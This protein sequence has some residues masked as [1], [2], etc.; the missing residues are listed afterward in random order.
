MYLSTTRFKAAAIAI[1]ACV[2]AAAA[3]PA[4]A[5]TMPDNN[6]DYIYRRMAQQSTEA[7]SVG[8]ITVGWDNGTDN[9]NIVRGSGVLVGGKYVL[10][11]AH[12][13]DDSTGGFFTIRGQTYN[14][15]RFVVANQFYNRGLDTDP[16]PDQRVFGIGADLALIELDRHVQ[17][18]KRIKAKISKSRKEKNKKATIVG[19][20]TGGNGTE[21]IS[22]AVLPGDGSMGAGDSTIWDYVPTK[23][24]GKN[25]IEP[26]RAF[27]GNPN[28]VRELTTDFDVNPSLLDS[29]RTE[30]GLQL[31]S[32]LYNSFTD[33]YTVTQDDVPITGEYMPSVGDSG[34]GLFINGKL[35]GITSWTT[36][37][38]SEYFSQAQYTRLSVGWWKWVR[39]NIRAFNRL[40]RNPSLVPWLKTSNGGAG[41]RG[42]ARIYAESDNT[43]A[44]ITEGQVLRIFGPGLF[45][46]EQPA[47]FAVTDS[48]PG[49]VNDYFSSS[50]AP[51]PEPT[52]LALLGLGGLA[53]LRRR[54]GR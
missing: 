38:N 26:G 39:D 29:L 9:A 36:R 41:F 33:T 43:D 31:P 2:I 8:E 21:G 32:H 50:P 44:G 1:S 3:T 23:R 53:V 17:G 49:V 34:G 16:N 52:S 25:I 7:R 40:N 48:F 18:A 13:I 24:A 6:Y 10:T 27:N 12:L 15:R 45:Y 11:A 19:F 22:T 42:V 20:G 35:A 54:A 46:N 5:G 51:L 28:Q 37:A 30:S 47:H 14:I 4:P